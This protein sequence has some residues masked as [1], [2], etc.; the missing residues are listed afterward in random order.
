MHPQWIYHLTA[1]MPT[2]IMVIHASGHGLVTVNDHK[3]VYD[4]HIVAVGR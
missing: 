2:V 1:L 3:L 4:I